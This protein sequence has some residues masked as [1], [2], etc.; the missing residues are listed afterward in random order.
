MRE[1]FTNCTDTKGQHSNDMNLPTF[2]SFFSQ[3]LAWF[4][5]GKDIKTWPTLWCWNNAYTAL[6]SRLNFLMTQH[7]SA[8]LHFSLGF[9]FYKHVPWFGWRDK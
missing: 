3:N 2:F 1:N 9:Y 5:K 4:T 6:Q 8:L 7:V